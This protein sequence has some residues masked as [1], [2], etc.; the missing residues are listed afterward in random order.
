MI[1]VTDD[2]SQNEEAIV[3]FSFSNIPKSNTSVSYEKRL[4]IRPSGVVSKNLMGDLK[5]ALAISLNSLAA[6]DAA[7][8]ENTSI[9]RRAKIE[10]PSTH[11]IYTPK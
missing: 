5:T 2:M 7:P 4:V 9:R 6:A 3:P 11:K 1:T 8:K 10:F